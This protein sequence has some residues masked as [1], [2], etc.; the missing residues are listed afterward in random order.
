M[1]MDV[2][3]NANMQPFDNDVQGANT[4]NSLNYKSSSRIQSFL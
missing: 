2:F 3:L 4:I 1:S